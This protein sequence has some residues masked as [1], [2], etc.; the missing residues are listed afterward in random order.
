MTYPHIL[1]YSMLGLNLF[2]WI[3]TGSAW[4]ALFTLIVLTVL[5]LE[6]HRPEWFK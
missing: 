1:A 2:F 6:W 4:S 3:G 5:M